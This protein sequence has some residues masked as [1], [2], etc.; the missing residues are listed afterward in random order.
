MKNKKLASNTYSFGKMTE[1]YI[2]IGFEQPANEVTNNYT[3]IE[4]WS[5]KSTKSANNEGETGYY[6][7]GR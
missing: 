6:Q 1:N 5:C 3:E 7:E 2:I 4:E